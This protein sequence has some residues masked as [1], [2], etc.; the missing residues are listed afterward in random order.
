MSLPMSGSVLFESDYIHEFNFRFTKNYG[1]ELDIPK[2]FIGIDKGL[3]LYTDETRGPI[4]QR[5]IWFQF[6]GIQS[7]RKTS[8]KND[9]TD[10]INAVNI[11]IEHINYWNSFGEPV[12]LVVYSEKDREFYYIDCEKIQ[13]ESTKEQVNIKISKEDIINEVFFVNQRELTPSIRTDIA[14]YKG[15]ALAINSDPLRSSISKLNESVYIRLITRLLQCH[16]FIESEKSIC[17]SGEVRSGVL[18]DSLETPIYWTVSYGFSD[19]IFRDNGEFDNTSGKLRIYIVPNVDTF[20]FEELQNSQGDQKSILFYN[21]EETDSL[22]GSLRNI[23]ILPIS[24]HSLTYNLILS[25]LLFN[26]FKNEV[27]W[28]N[29]NPLISAS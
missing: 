16:N 10:F 19:S 29:L 18:L 27:K 24:N 5:K 3:V 21:D 28:S 9:T 15:R 6:K 26:E 7:G 23:N 11:S 12:Y 22:F 2:D 4:G 20:D 13:Y 1:L 8:D 14:T 17:S 25:P